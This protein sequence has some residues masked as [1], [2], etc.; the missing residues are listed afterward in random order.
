M[1]SV[2]SWINV[3]MGQEF[4]RSK[5]CFRNKPRL[6]Y[7]DILFLS[8]GFCSRRPE[9]KAKSK[10]WSPGRRRH[11]PLPSAE[12]LLGRRAGRGL[13]ERIW[14]ARRTMGRGR[15]G[16]FFLSLPLPNVP[17]ALHLL[18]P[19][20]PP[21]QSLCGGE[22]A[23][24]RAVLW[25]SGDVSGTGTERDADWVRSVHVALVASNASAVAMWRGLTGDARTQLYYS[26]YFFLYIFFYC[27]GLAGRE[28]GTNLLV[29]KSQSL[30]PSDTA[31]VRKRSYASEGWD[32]D[33]EPWERKMNLSGDP[34][35]A[36]LRR[37][38]RNKATNFRPN[39][40]PGSLPIN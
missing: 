26:F 21:Q 24:H 18:S 20:S 5:T 33:A 17:R 4:I 31:A 36:S 1:W 8:K 16:S 12:A 30:I 7:Q 34:T 25:A 9:I 15:G 32:T 38:A 10:D 28:G 13:G 37:N 27:G 6:F 3:K 23:T 40:L 39:R 22:R 2:S 11:S 14:S 35:H 29:R 19:R